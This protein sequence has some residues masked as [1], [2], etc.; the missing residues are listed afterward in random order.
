MSDLVVIHK[1]TYMGETLEFSSGNKS[2]LI[3]QQPNFEIAV[4]FMPKGS[5]GIFYVPGGAEMTEVNYTNH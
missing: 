2:H 3:L 5:A 1:G 4:D